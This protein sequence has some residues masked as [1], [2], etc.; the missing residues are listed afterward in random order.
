M[1]LAFADDAGRT[2]S[3]TLS[4]PVKAVTAPLIREALRELELGENSALLSVSW[5]G[6]MSE[7]Q[8]VDGVTPITVMR[9]LSLLQWAIVPVFIAYLIYEVA[10]Q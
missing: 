4:T 3:I 2:R 6:K 1:S 10:T 5:L 9:L 7:K 8:Y